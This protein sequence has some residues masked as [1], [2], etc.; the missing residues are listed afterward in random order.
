LARRPARA[1]VTAAPRG[2]SS[3]TVRPDP[4]ALGLELGMLDR[5]RAE[6]QRGDAAQALRELQGYE[7]DAPEG[8][9]RLEVTLLRM[10]AHAA[11]GDMTRARALAAE[12]VARP[13][14]PL[15]AARA[16]EILNSREGLR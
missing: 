12:I 6:L 8:Q 14:S 4:H 16:R 5:A 7:H 2:S 15:H 13:V 3:A 9:L 11:L 1:S 10:E